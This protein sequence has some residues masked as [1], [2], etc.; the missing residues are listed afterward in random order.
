M[1]V[2]AAEP[3]FDLSRV[4]RAARL[5]V[6][7]VVI[8]LALATILAGI[9]RAPNNT[10]LDPR[11]TAPNGAHALAVLLGNRGVSVTIADELAQLASTRD[12]TIFV[13]RPAHLSERALDAIAATTATV[14]LVDPPARALSALGVPATVDAVTGA[15]VLAPRCTLAA[16]TTAGPVRVDGDLYAVHGPATRCYLQAG[17]AALVESTRSNG[18]TTIVLGAGST[19]S[20][21]QLA[22]QGNAALALGLLST[23]KVQWVPA[24]LHAG[25][26]A[27]SQQGLFNLLPTRLLWAT[28]ALFFALV[29]L[30]LSRARRLG[31]PVVEP[32]P[33]VVRAS[34]TVEG[35][36][37]LL[38]AA[39]ARGSAA[40]SLR[41]ASVRRL[42]N[43]LR[44]GAEEDPTAVAA[45][46]AERTH[47]PAGDVTSVLYGGEPSDDAALVRLAQRLPSLESELRQDAG[48][49][50][51]GQP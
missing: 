12:D 17:D 26:V 5:P 34:E 15:A 51:G 3:P 11:N 2:I 49:A 33:V 32:L 7:L 20:N 18:A 31:R 42:T 1:S 43:T 29:V 48:P 35:R 44:L 50:T 6:A 37:N 38:H 47:T 30:A 24:G 14:L 40:R 28:L 13:T 10:T 19:L 4:W 46:V 25:V 36:A 39:R 22:A 9:G 21:A 27:R 23:A 16:A 8:G 41:T 45:L